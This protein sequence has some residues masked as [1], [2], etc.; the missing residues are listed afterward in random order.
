ME[1]T[2]QSIE[3]PSPLGPQTEKH[4]YMFP[5]LM[6]KMMKNVS[7]QVQFESSLM[8]TALILLG[9]ILMAAYLFLF[10]EQTLYY[11]IILGINLI[12]GFIFMSSSLITTYQQYTSYMDVVDFQKSM[13]MAQGTPQPKRYNRKNQF[14]FF[15]G[16]IIFIA[17]F[18]IPGLIIDQFSN[19][20]PYEYYILGLMLLIGVLLM[21]AAIKKPK[22]K[23]VLI[24]P[25]QIMRSPVAPAVAQ[26]QIM[27]TPVQQPGRSTQEMTR[28]VQ[29]RPTIQQMVRPAVQNK[30]TALPVL[31]PA[32]KP[33]VQQQS[34]PAIQ[35]RPALQPVQ[36]QQIPAQRQIQAARPVIQTQQR[37]T[38]QLKPRPIFKPQV[39]QMRAVYPNE[40]N[41]AAPNQ[42]PKKPGFFDRFKRTKSTN[43][44]APTNK[45]SNKKEQ[46]MI[47]KIEQSFNKQM[48]D[49]DHLKNKERR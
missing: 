30:P 22:K 40:I 36:R 11:K 15:G 48:Y 39:Q 32:I 19:M 28:I 17:G 24:Q 26:K 49:I 20:G 35:Q 12:G 14:L 45:P 31:K 9:L 21:I 27:K 33:Q 46:E 13:G 29:S 1:Q 4:K 3:G 38:Q 23:K 2:Q 8:A 18:F 16:L 47:N 7:M 42:Q 34:R 25:R 43:A 5:N 6:A 10:G 41:E 44:Q 37:P